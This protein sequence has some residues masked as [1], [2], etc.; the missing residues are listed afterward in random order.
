MTV[1]TAD[2][3]DERGPELESIAL[4]FGDFGAKDS[5][6]GPARTVRC[7]QDNALAKSTL[8]QPSD[9]AVLIIDGGGSIATALMGDMIAELAVSNGWAG[10]VINGAVRDRVALSSMGL[11]IK[12]LASNPRKSAK[13]GEGE[14]DVTLEIGGATIRPGAM[15]FADPDGV[16]VEK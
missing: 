2:L 1:S 9:G 3:W 10:V 11:G 14:L 15:V 4:N 16:V 5:F 12:A 13:T 6:S 7:Y 8:S